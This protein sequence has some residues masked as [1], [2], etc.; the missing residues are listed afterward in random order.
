MKT[1]TEGKKK[2]P[3]T[4]SFFAFMLDNSFRPKWKN[5]LKNNKILAA[6]T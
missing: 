2:I 1:R 5:I 3:E 4:E 6:N